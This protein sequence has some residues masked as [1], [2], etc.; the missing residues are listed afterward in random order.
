VACVI[1]SKVQGVVGL[2]PKVLCIGYR[3][4]TGEVLENEKAVMPSI[5]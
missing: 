4:S 5:L 2:N 1:T 3:R